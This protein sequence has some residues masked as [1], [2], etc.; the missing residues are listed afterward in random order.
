MKVILIFFALFC[1]GSALWAQ[2]CIYKTAA[3]FPVPDSGLAYTRC[4]L[5]LHE[6][7]HTQTIG[8]NCR[9]KKTVYLKSDVYGYR[10][11]EGNHYRL[12]AGAA[13]QV[14]NPGDSLL[15]YKTT[16]GTGLKNNPVIDLYF[17][18]RNKTTPVLSLDLAS[19]N[20]AYGNNPGF[21][22]LLET[23]FTSNAQLVAYEPLALAHQL[24]RLLILSTQN[25]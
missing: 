15:L 13:Y 19:L 9:G 18:S 22:A 2:A 10:D 11:R 21:L 17:F 8:V 14:L 4:R 7:F 25:N 6:V 20:L 12:Q 1:T 23:A 16:T 24:N 3:D 5:M